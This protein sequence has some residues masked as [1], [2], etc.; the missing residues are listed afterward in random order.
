V[1]QWVKILDVS[2]MMNNDD[3]DGVVRLA[4]ENIPE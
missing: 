2:M 1:P 3:F 4:I